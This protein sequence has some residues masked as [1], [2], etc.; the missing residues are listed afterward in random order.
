[1]GWRTICSLPLFW[2]LLIFGTLGVLLKRFCDGACP[3]GWVSGRRLWSFSAAVEIGCKFID[4]IA[5]DR[6]VIAHLGAC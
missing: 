2:K 6:D 5:A 4:A 1:M 3:V